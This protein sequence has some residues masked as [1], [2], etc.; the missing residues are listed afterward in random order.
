MNNIRDT[1]NAKLKFVFERFAWKNRYKTG[2]NFL[3]K[4]NR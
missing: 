2:V 1:F 3:I 4:Y